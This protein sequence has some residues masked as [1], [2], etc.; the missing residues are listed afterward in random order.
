MP[1][2]THAPENVICAVCKQPI[3][4]EQRP[5]VFMKDGAEVH[6]ECWSA[7]ELSP[8][9][10]DPQAASE[11]AKHLAWEK[12][13]AENGWSCRICGAFPELGQQLEDNVCEDCKI[14]LRN[15][16]PTVPN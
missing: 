9:S 5:S 3:L 1:E 16:D 10:T 2:E 4:A 12:L 15:Y 13:C 14:S 6:I 11:E 7:A 8:F